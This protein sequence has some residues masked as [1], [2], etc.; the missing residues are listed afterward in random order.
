MD[1]RE[2]LAAMA[3]VSALG[4][5]DTRPIPNYRIV[6]RFKPA[7]RPGMPGPY[8]GRVV[9]VHSPRCIDEVTEKVDVPTVKAMM[10]R[11][12]TTLTGDKDP[13]DS[14][15]RF[16]NA[17]DYVGVKINC[18][19][20]PGAMSMPDIVAEIAH[21]LIAVGV[22]A[23]S[24]VIHERGGGQILS[25]KYPEFVPAGVRVESAVRGSASILACTSKPISTAGRHPLLPSPYGHRA[26]HE[27]HQRA[28]H[29]GP[30]RVGRDGCL[31]N[32]AY[33][34]FDNVARSHYKSQTETRTFI[35]TLANVEPLRSRTVLQIMDGLRGV[36]HAGPFSTDKRYRFYLNQM[37]F[38]TDPVAMDRFLIDV[39]DNK[40]KQE[41]AISVWERDM[42]YYSTRLEDWQADPNVNRFIREPGHIEYAG[43]L[44]LG[45]YDTNK[46]Q[47]TEITL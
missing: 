31:K 39:I 29:E 3:A 12:M 21:N 33:G 43:T 5:P 38:G 40:R 42:K 15:A 34:E 2:F 22:K 36:W 18:S 19:G 45:V 35:G 47:H 27:D 26:V 4:V 1:R 9:T 41:G 24:I 30:R 20:A 25:A 6:T 44:G 28:E 7:A 46:I 17:Q 23:T 16:F 10:A 37:K 32:I 8:P 14:W 13:R 11:G